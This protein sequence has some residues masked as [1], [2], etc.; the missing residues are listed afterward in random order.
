MWTCCGSDSV[1]GRRLPETHALCAL[2]VAGDI[3]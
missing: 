1:A 3:A 2:L